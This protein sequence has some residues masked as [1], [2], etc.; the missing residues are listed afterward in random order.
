MKQSETRRNIVQRD[1]TTRPAV[2]WLGFADVVDASNLGGQRERYFVIHA[3]GTA[4][5]FGKSYYCATHDQ[6]LAN[7]GNLA[8]HIDAGGEHQLVVWCRKHRTYEAP[9]PGDVAAVLQAT[10]A[11]S[12]SDPT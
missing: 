8:M 2:S 7:L 9:D 10:L 1:E 12:D 4:A 3:C 6:Q 5:A 11:L